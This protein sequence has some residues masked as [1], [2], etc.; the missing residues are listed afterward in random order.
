MNAYH[1]SQDT[2]DLYSNGASEVIVGKALKKYSIPRS[3]VVILSKL[4]FPICEGE[5]TRVRPVNDGP[6]V[7]Q[8]GLSRKHIFDAV[9]NSLR[10]LDLDYIGKFHHVTSFEIGVSADRRK[11][12]TRFF[13][14]LE[15]PLFDQ[16]VLIESYLLDC[17]LDVN[18]GNN[19]TSGVLVVD[20][21]GTASSLHSVGEAMLITILDRCSSNSSLGSRNSAR[22]NHEGTTRC[23]HVW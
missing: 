12:K 4:Y 2:A 13:E 22:G 8:M 3:K 5:G 19:Q 17:Q 15:L 7:N 23:S 6:V 9:D 21:L 10:R 14:M 16:C 18:T 11:L 20:R 1:V